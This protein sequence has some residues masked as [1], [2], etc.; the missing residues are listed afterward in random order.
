MMKEQK[1]QNTG[2]ARLFKN[3]FLEMLTKGHPALS[4]GIH[5]PIFVY[6][7]YYGY[8]TYDMS[9]LFMFGIFIFALFFWT[10]FEYIAHRYI[11]HLIS[12]KQSLQKL[13][14]DIQKENKNRHFYLFCTNYKMRTTIG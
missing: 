13:P 4:W 3:P 5:V 2:Q 12:E 11:F 6:C 10:F 1:V 9:I 8:I 14:V 7:F